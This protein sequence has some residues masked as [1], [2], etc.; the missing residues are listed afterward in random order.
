MPTQ[1]IEK[2][3]DWLSK[4]PKTRALHAKSFPYT[5]SNKVYWKPYSPFRETP[6]RRDP[7][8]GT[9][10]Q[11]Q[12]PP[13]G[14]C[15]GIWINPK[16]EARNTKPKFK[17]PK[18]KWPKHLNQEHSLL[19]HLSLFWANPALESLHAFS[20]DADEPV[21]H[22]LTSTRKEKMHIADW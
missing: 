18:S 13:W 1:E 7:P 2:K 12:V 5:L 17:W 9:G 8:Q 20:L 11:P 4:S 19:E 22:N 15:E 3:E 6:P 10:V 21:K 16:S 14:S